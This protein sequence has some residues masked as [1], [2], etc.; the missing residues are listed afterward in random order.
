MHWLGLFLNHGKCHMC[1]KGRFLNECLVIKS[2]NRRTNS[3]S[4][5]IPQILPS[6]LD[7]CGSIS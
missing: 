7:S 3:K 2:I 6:L 5:L 1:H 4:N